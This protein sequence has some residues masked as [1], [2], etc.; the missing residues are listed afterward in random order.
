MAPCACRMSSPLAMM[1]SASAMVCRAL[2]MARSAVMRVFSLSAMLWMQA[3][4]FSSS[5]AAASMTARACSTAAAASSAAGAAAASV[6]AL[7]SCAFTAAS[8]LPLS[9]MSAPWPMLL[10]PWPPPAW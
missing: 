3:L 6:S 9:V 10:A 5:G 7:E 4:I 1:A 8:R 2:W